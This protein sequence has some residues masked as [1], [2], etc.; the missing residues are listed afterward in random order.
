MNAPLGVVASATT[1]NKAQQLPTLLAQQCWELSRP[2]AR[3]LSFPLS[4]L[5]GF[6]KKAGF[7][8]K[9]KIWPKKY[10]KNQDR[11]SL[12]LK[13]EHDI[14]IMENAIKINVGI[15]KRFKQ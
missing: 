2:F 11:H 8:N 15:A 13:F 7:V 9:T 3:S 12:E 4:I 5:K 1:A 10:Y 6:T 14:I